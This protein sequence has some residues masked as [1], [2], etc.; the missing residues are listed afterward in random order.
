MTDCHAAV[1]LGLCLG[2]IGQ[3][4]PYGC[5]TKPSFERPVHSETCL[6]LLIG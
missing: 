3:L 6:R 5:P 2:E 1:N 4:R